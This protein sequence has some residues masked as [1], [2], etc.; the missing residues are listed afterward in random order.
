MR[1]EVVYRFWHLAYSVES[2]GEATPES[3]RCYVESQGSKEKPRKA[4]PPA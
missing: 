2:V 4:K 3:V 1:S